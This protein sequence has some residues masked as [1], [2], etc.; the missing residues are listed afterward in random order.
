MGKQV[1]SELATQLSDTTLSP[2]VS[3]S[4]HAILDATVRAKLA[5]EAARLREGDDALRSA[6]ETA[7]ERENIDRER[8]NDDHD[9][10]HDHD[11]N[12]TG[13]AVEH[14]NVKNS[15]VLLGDLEEV[16][17]KVDRYRARASL[18]D[19]PEVKEA[20]EAVASCYRTNSTTTLNCWSEVAAFRNAVAK[21]EQVVVAPIFRSFATDAD[22]V[23]FLA[24]RRLAT[25]A[26]RS[27][28]FLAGARARLRCPRMFTHIHTSPLHKT[29]R[30]YLPP[31][32]TP[33][34]FAAS[35][36]C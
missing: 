24:I 8:S 12:G 21:L 7:L 3:P 13:G 6:I 14:G 1:S 4:R 32:M 5:A 36:T 17:Q 2:E 29:R 11:G 27:G 23:S 15:T 18:V 22:L 20:S 25:V 9:H 16:R 33:S 28:R 31:C 26:R 34:S 35:E 10:D 30:P 19:H